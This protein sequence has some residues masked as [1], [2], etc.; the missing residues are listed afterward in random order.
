MP[1]MVHG[2]GMGRVLQQ[3]PKQGVPMSNGNPVSITFLL[4]EAGNRTVAKAAMNRHENTIRTFPAAGE[5]C[6]LVES[7]A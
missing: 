7:K 1:C 6:G 4:D 3:R 2:N 5:F